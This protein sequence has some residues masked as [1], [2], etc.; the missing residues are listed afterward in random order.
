[1]RGYVPVGGGE[2]NGESG[3]WVGR[4]WRG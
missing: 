4:E 3:A 1:V 2:G